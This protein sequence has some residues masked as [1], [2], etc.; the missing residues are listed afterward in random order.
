MRDRDVAY[1]KWDGKLLH[2]FSS[3][4]TDYML[5]AT[6]LESDNKTLKKFRLMANKDAVTIVIKVGNMT[7]QV[8]VQSLEFGVN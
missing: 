4:I 2:A 8:R 1:K 6:I 3:L 7:H 5:C